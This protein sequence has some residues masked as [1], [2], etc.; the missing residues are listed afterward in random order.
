MER[1]YRCPSC[2]GKRTFDDRIELSDEMRCL[3]CESV[4]NDVTSY[5]KPKAGAAPVTKP[6][7]LT[8]ELDDLSSIPKVIYNGEDITN[9]TRIDF[10]WITREDEVFVNESPYINL[11]YYEKDKNDKYHLKSISF[12]KRSERNGS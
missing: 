4:M 3:R 9:R 7:L 2:D 8:I 6:K 10:S 5:Y 11:E 12:N 1:L